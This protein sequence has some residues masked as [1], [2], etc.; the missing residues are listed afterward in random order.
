M[1][2]TILRGDTDLCVI[3]ADSFTGKPD[4]KIFVGKAA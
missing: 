3:P 1:Q 4:Y 2:M